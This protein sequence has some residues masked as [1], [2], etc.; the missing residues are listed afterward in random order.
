MRSRA[1]SSVV[2]HG[3]RD[4]S[5]AIV[6]TGIRC[7]WAGDRASVYMYLYICTVKPPGHVPEA[8]MALRG[9][10]HGCGARGGRD[11]SRAFAKS[12]GHEGA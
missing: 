10:L 5:G 1:S 9:L 7:Q 11:L 3:M 4:D 8:M 12:D 6:T 2:V